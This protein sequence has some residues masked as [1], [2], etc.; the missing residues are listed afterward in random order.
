[1]QQRRCEPFLLN[2]AE[3]TKGRNNMKIGHLHL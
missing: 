3:L 2:T 1:M